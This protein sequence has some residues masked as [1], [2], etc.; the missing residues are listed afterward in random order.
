MTEFVNA[1]KIL[2]QNDLNLGKVIDLIK[3]EYQKKE[4]DDFTSLVKIIIGQQLS[5]SAAKTI[6]TRVENY[7]GEKTFN[8]KT[9]E[10][11]SNKNLRLC[12]I[13]NAKVN[14]IKS[15]SETLIQTPKYFTNLRKNNADQILTELCKIK[16]VGIWTASI[17]AMGSLNHKNIFPYGDVSLNKAI[18]VIYKEDLNQEEV[19]SKWSPYKSYACRV[20]WQWV[21]KGMPNIS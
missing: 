17:F 15:F 11:A 10:S 8:L 12:G 14:Y 20:L 5:N 6:I 9:I 16:G 1:L 4:D 2:K 7:L 18:K 19:I 13:S 3:P 21:D